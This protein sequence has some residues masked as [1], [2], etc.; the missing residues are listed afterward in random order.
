ME[1]IHRARRPDG[2]KKGT[3]QGPAQAEH[4]VTVSHNEESWKSEQEFNRIM[5]NPF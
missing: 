4:C 2:R 5:E 1:K 3:Q